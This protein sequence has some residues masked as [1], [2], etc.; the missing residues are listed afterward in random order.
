[1]VFF[2]VVVGRTTPSAG[3]IE[4]SANRGARDAADTLMG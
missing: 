2:V 4:T 3:V 1:L